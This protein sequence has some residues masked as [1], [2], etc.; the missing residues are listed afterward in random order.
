MVYLTF[1]A[2]GQY[3]LTPW[4]YTTELPEDYE[5]LVGT[6]FFFVITCTGF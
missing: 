3:W 4:G 5:E 2:F 6:N 1:H